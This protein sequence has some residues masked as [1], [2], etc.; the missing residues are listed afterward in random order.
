M[1]TTTSGS[2]AGDGTVRV[3]WPGRYRDAHGRA[4]EVAMVWPGDRDGREVRGKLVEGEHLGEFTTDLNT[5]WQTW[6]RA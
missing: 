2:G 3:P 5:F 4:F 6:V 1:E